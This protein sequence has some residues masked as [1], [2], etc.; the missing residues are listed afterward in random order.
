V[1]EP[2]ID[3]V[4]TLYFS[5]LQRWNSQ[6]AAGMAALF[7]PGGAVVGF[8]GTQ[9]EGREAIEASM[10]EVFGHH[11]TPAFIA[12]VRSV[13]IVDRFAILRAVA[14]MVAPGQQDLNPELNTIQTVIASNSDGPWRVELFQNTPAAL[15]ERPQERERLTAELREVLRR[16]GGAA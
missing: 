16:T 1:R 5:L 15:H 13:R 3:D 14:G 10:R 2:K 7:T 6:D 9:L 4:E 12:T 8:D 11:Q